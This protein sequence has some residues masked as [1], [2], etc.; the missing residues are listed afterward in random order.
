MTQSFGFCF[1][2][3]SEMMFY[4]NEGVGGEKKKIIIFS[5]LIGSWLRPSY[6]KGQSNRRKTNTNLVT[7]TPPV[8]VGET[9]E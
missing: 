5:I 3:V 7:R 2:M 9:M 4:F 8:Y 1:V 6:H